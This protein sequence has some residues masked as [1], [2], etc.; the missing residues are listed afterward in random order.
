LIVSNPSLTSL[1]KQGYLN[2]KSR[3]QISKELGVSTGTVSKII[4]EWKLRIGIPIAEVLRDFAVLVKKSDITIEQCAEGYRMKNIMKNLG[5]TD[6]INDDNRRINYDEFSFF[7]KEIYMNCKR[8]GIKPN[9]ILSWIKDLFSWYSPSGNLLVSLVNGKR[10]DGEEE[11]VE[12]V[13]EERNN[14]KTMSSPSPK[15]PYISQEAKPMPGSNSDEF[16]INQ[17]SNAFTNNITADFNPKQNTGSLNNMETPF[18]SQISNYIAKKKKECRELENYKWKL[19]K[20]IKIKESKKNQIEFELEQLKQDKKYVMTF[21]DWFY[22]LKRELWE[23]F[24]IKIEDFGTFTSVINDFKKNGFDIVKIMEKYISAISLED[25]IKKESDE[26]QILHSQK[27]ESNKSVVLW[28]E[29]VN[30]HQQTMNI[31]YQLEDMNLGLKELK[32]LRYLILEVSKA[33]KISPDKAVLKFLDDIE[34]DYDNKLGF[35]TKLKEKQDEL[36]FLNN[37]VI[38][39]RTILQSQSSIGVA[40]S[41]LLQK[42]ITESD[43]IN[44]NQLVEVCTKSNNIDFS[45]SK[46]GNQNE[47]FTTKYRRNTDDSKVKSE[48]WKM[49]INDL[50]RYGDIKAAVQKYQINA[51]KLQKRVYNLDK[52]KQESTNYIQTASSFINSLNNEISYYKGFIDQIQDQ[53]NKINLSSRVSLVPIFILVNKNSERDDERDDENNR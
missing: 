38:N 17:S 50:K 2:G 44:I 41:N 19:E 9:I 25:K 15:T 43:I 51:E 33:N 47:N 28:Q 20:D 37:K 52:Q 22:D 21:I 12:E 49:W 45:N 10:I 14:K 5:I 35:E 27:I 1:V 48:Y 4:K 36:A 8:L 6:D 42:G 31:Y 24:T 32:Q 3:D 23:R 26:L 16:I 34:K 30:Q 29:Q 18:V 53:K 46:I 40:L 7:V 39:C 11:E 13:E